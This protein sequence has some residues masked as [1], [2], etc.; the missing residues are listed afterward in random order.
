VR[1]DLGMGS[2]ELSG[3]RQHSHNG[4]CSSAFGSCG[5]HSCSRGECEVTFP[6]NAAARCH[7]ITRA[8]QQL[9]QVLYRSEKWHK[10]FA[11][12]WRA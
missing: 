2:S 10:Q 4:T 1:M 12:E 9:Q 7:R 8:P 11:K 6:A 3:P 5:L